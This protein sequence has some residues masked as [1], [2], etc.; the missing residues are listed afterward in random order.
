MKKLKLIVGKRQIVIVALLVTLSVAAFLNWQ[1][2]TGDH[3]V[4]VMDSSDK[5]ANN[6]EENK[7]NSKN[8]QNYGEA[9]LVSKNENSKSDFIKQTRLNKAAAYDEE[10]ENVNKLIN[11][12][13]LNETDKNDLTK[14]LMDIISKKETE[15]TVENEIKSKDFIEDA[16]V[17]IE[18]KNDSANAYIKSKNNLNQEQTTQITDIIARV[19]NFSSSNIIVTPIK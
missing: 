14:Q 5:S 17:F 19:T 1:F 2:A 18:N 6:E 3:A 10:I 7:E 15:T 16:L 11:N 13:N 8:S 4:T 9:E 12:K